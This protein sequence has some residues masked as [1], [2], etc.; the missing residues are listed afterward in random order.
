MEVIIVYMMA[1]DP[2]VAEIGSPSLGRQILIEMSDLGNQ[3]GQQPGGK[4]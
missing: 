2:E 1:M 4:C 3:E